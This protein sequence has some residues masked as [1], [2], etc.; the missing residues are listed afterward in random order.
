MAP[1]LNENLLM[2]CVAVMMEL[3]E[4]AKLL[5]VVF[6]GVLTHV[7]VPE[8]RMGSLYRAGVNHIKSTLYTV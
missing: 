7:S 1:Q 3:T 5:F 4:R 8:P 2:P 6:R